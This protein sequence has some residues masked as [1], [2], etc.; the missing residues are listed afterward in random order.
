VDNLAVG[1]G[2]EVSVSSIKIDGSSDKFSATGFSITPLARYYFD[3][4]YIQGEMQ[5]GQNKTKSTVNNTVSE[6]KTKLGGWSILSGYAFF[7][8]D[9]IS[10]EPQLGYSVL[11]R[12]DPSNTKNINSGITIGMGI[13]AYINR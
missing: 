12:K 4:F 11:N 9:A 8:N 7:F 6:S 2:L 5:F 1:A 13:Y 10:F 3:H